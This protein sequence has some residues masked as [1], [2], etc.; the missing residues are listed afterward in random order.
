MYTNILKTKKFLGSIDALNSNETNLEKFLVEYGFELDTYYN[1][2][3]KFLKQI[4]GIE[5]LYVTIFSNT[6]ILNSVV[7]ETKYHTETK[8]NPLDVI[9]DLNDLKL[10]LQKCCENV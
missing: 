2:T 10:Y 4:G 6:N 1:H 9:K 8:T 3:K 5:Y 7:L